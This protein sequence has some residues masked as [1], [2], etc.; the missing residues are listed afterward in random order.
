[1]AE[2]HP[3]GLTRHIG[4]D[5]LPG[6]FVENLQELIAAHITHPLERRKL[7]L[8]PEHRGENE[9]KPAVLREVPQPP[10]YHGPHTL[11]DHPPPRLV[12]GDRFEH[13]FR[14]QQPHHLPDEEGVAL[15][16]AMEGADNARGWREVAR[17]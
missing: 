7:E 5:P 9:D 12:V 6:G 16:R 11:G 13:L 15:G 17:Q 4:D 14:P 8:A 3:T 1:V 2:A 10:P